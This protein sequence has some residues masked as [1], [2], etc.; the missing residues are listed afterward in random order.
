MQVREGGSQES[1]SKCT[2]SS[3]EE[4]QEKREAQAHAG[5]TEVAGQGC[6]M[7]GVGQKGQVPRRRVQQRRG[8]TERGQRAAPGAHSRRSLKALSSFLEE[9][10]ENT[11]REIEASRD[12]VEYRKCSILNVLRNSRWSRQKEV[13]DMGTGKMEVRGEWKET[14]I[15]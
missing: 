9:D 14:G 6:D 5:E 12:D 4:R 1:L 2:L 3:L 8:R 11:A 10:P 15:Q 7:L 13:R